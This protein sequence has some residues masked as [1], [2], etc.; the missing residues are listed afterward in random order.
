MRDDIND[1]KLTMDVGS[2]EPKRYSVDLSINLSFHLD[3]CY[4]FYYV[5]SDYNLLFTLHIY[6]YIYIYIYKR[7]EMIG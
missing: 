4:Q 3:R 2:V 7:S 6:I 1:F 5:L